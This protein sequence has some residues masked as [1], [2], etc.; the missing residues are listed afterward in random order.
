MDGFRFFDRQDDFSVVTKQ[1][2]HWAQAGTLVF[3]TW[4]TAD[5]LP[6]DVQIA[7]TRERQRT[8]ML[9]GLDP[10]TDW[11][12]ALEKLPPAERSRVKSKLFRLWDDRLDS[13]AGACVLRRPE[14]S[15][16]VEKSLIHFDGHRYLITDA[17]VMPNHVHLLAAF[18]DEPAMFEQCESWKRFT[19]LQI[20]KAIGRY[21]QFWQVE[22]FDHLVRSEEQFWYFQKYISENGRK[23]G[24][25]DGEYR[26][27]SKGLRNI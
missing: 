20:N 1:L 10:K 13:G 27:F 22:Q 4:R 8:L 15:A 19:A 18:P 25:K 14:L 23:A 26:W 24:L 17:I 7:L 21:G 6:R 2:P 12:A 5:S 16:I 11:K 9:A 3:I